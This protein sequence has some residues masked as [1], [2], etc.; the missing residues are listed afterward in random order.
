MDNTKVEKLRAGL[1]KVKGDILLDDVS[2]GLYSTDASLY[3]IQP[4]GTV[5]PRTQEDLQEVVRVVAE[6]KV[7]LLARG[8]GTSLAGQTVSDGLVVDYSKYLK[9]VLELNVEEKWVRVEPGIVLDNLNDYL[10]PHSL[11][12]A[13]D[14]ATSSRATIGGMIG[15]NSAGTRSVRY[16]KTI[17]HVLELK[18]I[19]S[20][21]QTLSLGRNNRVELDAKCSQ[22]NREGELY[23]VVRQV[24]AENREEILQ[25]Y[26]KVMRRVGGYNLDALLDE[27]NFNL[28]HLIVGSEGTLGSICEAKLSLEPIPN[29]RAVCVLHFD[30]LFNAIDAVPLI[31]EH[32]PTAVE[33][34][35]QK[36]LELAVANPSVAALCSQFLEGT[37]DSI[38]IVEFAGN[39][40]SEIR[41]AIDSLRSDARVSK[42]SYHTF[43][44]LTSEAQATVWAVRKNTLGVL[45]SIR[46][47]AKP[48]PF[49]EDVCVPVEHLSTY[50]RQ[51]LEI[52]EKHGRSAAL[53]AHASVGVIH[54]RPILNLKQQEDVEI[55]KAISNDVFDLTVHYGGSWSGEHGDGLVRSYKNREFFGEQLFNACKESKQA[56]DPAGL[57]NPGKVVFSPPMD[58]HLRI[59]PGY[60]AQLRATHF[61]FS[62]EQGFDRA[63]EMCTGVGQCRKTLTGAMC[64][65]Y[66]VT[67]DEEHSTRGRANALRL[68]MS[69]QLGEEGLG[70][71]GLYEA[72]D[73]C[74]ECKA[75]KT[76]CPSAVDMAKLKSEV[77]AQYRELHGLPLRKELFARAR[78][79]AEVGSRIPSLANWGS[80]LGISKWALEKVLGIDRR[81]K[82]P[83]YANRTFV[84]LFDEHYVAEPTASRR[85]AIF[86]DTFVNY[87]DPAVGVAAVR[88]LDAAGCSV[89]VTMPGCCGRP[90]ISCGL[91]KEAKNSGATTLEG[92]R[93]YAEEGVPVVV[94]EPSC[95]AAFRDDYLD[96]ID[97]QELARAVADVTVSLEEFLVRDEVKEDLA[98]VL[99]PSAE[100]I[101]FHGH[102]QQKALQGT[103]ASTAALKIGASEVNEIDAGC[104]GMAGSFGYEKSHYEVSKGIGDLKLFPAIR[105][106]ENNS[107]IAACGFSCR[108]QIEHFTGRK[109][110]HIA[111]VLASSLSGS[112]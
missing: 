80:N 9:R 104:C 21:G 90:M 38:L 92:L 94:L 30:S 17:D 89:E 76:E 109:A 27:E 87:H 101:L 53:Y 75:C 56:V 57:M 105:R 2:R 5:L 6:L 60:H 77:L 28:A 41:S 112:D 66:M 100:D 46:G 10:L 61:R 18:V 47:D 55:M 26:P 69:G 24:V 111:E 98:S 29:S 72:L 23:K 82:L 99:S 73:L 34:L 108:S 49:I 88:L 42:L 110:L 79:S 1:G 48:I 65:S 7:A 13:P 37:P 85:V 70:N 54:V 20:D 64:P 39:T 32:G 91:L 25:R 86:A 40:A 62:E 59:H 106:A 74:L 51:V 35:D 22:G 93:K 15:N 81:R 58:E 31:L 11:F 36:G 107:V 96:L 3:Q 33:I 97:D 50:I 95:L 68:A 78:V 84:S 67:L 103:S 14:V 71:P 45:L 4:L 43:E 102:C 52:T 44:G 83:S 8:G 19:T 63:V 16:G 12:F